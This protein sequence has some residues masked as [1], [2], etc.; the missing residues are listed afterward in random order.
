MDIAGV[1]THTKT[2]CLL[3]LLP[4]VDF[5]GVLFH[6]SNPGGDKNIIRVGLSVCVCVRA[7]VCVCVRVYMYVRV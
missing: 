6:V 5:D 3:I 7:C 2:V 1:S 4:H